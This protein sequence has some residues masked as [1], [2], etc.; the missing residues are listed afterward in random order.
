MFQ[1]VQE[2]FRT[3]P[4]HI[5]SEEISEIMEIVRNLGENDG[6]FFIV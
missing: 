2:F 1:I 6:E 4:A 3:A 5:L